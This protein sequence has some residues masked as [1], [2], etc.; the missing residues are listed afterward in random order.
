MSDMLKK[1]TEYLAACKKTQ[2][3]KNAVHFD[4]PTGWM[5]DPNGVI[6]AFGK[7][8]VFYQ[9]YPFAAEPR[10]IFWG[11]AST[12]DF[13]HWET[14]PPALAP[15]MPYDQ[16]GCWSGSAIMH[17]GKIYL[18]YTG[19]SKGIQQQCLACSEDGIHFEKYGGNPVIRSEQ[20]PKGIDPY[21]FRDPYVIR[22]DNGFVVF[23]GA[24]DLENDCGCVLVYKSENLFVWQYAGRLIS[25]K[26]MIHPGIVECPSYAEFG[27]KSVLV[28]SLNFMPTSGRLHRNFADTVGL[29]GDANLSVPSF[30]AE[31]EKLLDY[32]FDYYAPQV[33]H[34]NDGRKIL[35]G[36]MQ[37]WEVSYPTQRYGWVGSLALPRELSLCDNQLRMQ[38]V[39]ELGECCRQVDQGALAGG[40]GKKEIPLEGIC[41]IRM[42][43]QDGMGFGGFQIVGSD[44]GLRCCYYSETKEIIMRRWGIFVPQSKTPLEDD[45]WERI[46][47]C[48]AP[49]E[50]WLD[51]WID[52]SSVEVFINCGEAVMTSTYFLPDK[53]I[54]IL[55]SASAIEYFVYSIETE[56]TD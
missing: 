31:T 7:Y 25:R 29:V 38:P 1:A 20:L 47:P 36:W 53:K 37:M 41:R 16:N 8:H 34:T 56:D 46:Y 39:R 35:I 51:A 19:N 5:N 23:L 13:I 43:V 4:V 52:I 28:A 45:V 6:D 24:K 3:F 44:G 14:L 15:D 32:G 49:G 50:I 2:K 48:N 10:D 54:E 12:S 55:E 42:K 22:K 26:E 18:M 17:Q 21:A 11:H 33:L 40:T 9:H 30:C 27:E